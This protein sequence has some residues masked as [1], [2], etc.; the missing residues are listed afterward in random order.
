MLLLG[1]YIDEGMGQK[2]LNRRKIAVVGGK[3]EGRPARFV[4][5]ID[6]DGGMTDE[7]A[8]DI[9]VANQSCRL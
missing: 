3:D 4:G 7:N 9:F 2:R 5:G 1:I 8:D 6:F